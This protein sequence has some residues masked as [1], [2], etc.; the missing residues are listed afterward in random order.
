MKALILVSALVFT[1][2]TIAGPAGSGHSHGHSHSHAAPAVL[3]EQTQEIGKFHISRLVKSQKLEGSWNEAI[4]DQSEKKMLGGKEEWV[5]TFTNQKSSK[6]KKI[7]IFLKASGE[8]IAAN[9]TGK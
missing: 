7:F 9:F 8:F 4:Y 3:K 5:V 6:D 2:T 1:T